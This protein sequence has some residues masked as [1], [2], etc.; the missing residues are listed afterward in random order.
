[1]TD[2]II[3]L[4]VIGKLLELRKSRKNLKN[5]LTELT[6]YDI[7]NNGDNA[8]EKSKAQ[9]DWITINHTKVQID[10]NG[11]LA[12]AVGEKIQNYEPKGASGTSPKAHTQSREE[13]KQSLIA[14]WEE[15]HGESLLFGKGTTK[16]IEN[17]EAKHDLMLEARAGKPGEPIPIAQAQKGANPLYNKEKGYDGNCQ[18]CAV[19]YDLRRR[20]YDVE[21]QPSA[22][23]DNA[24]LATTSCIEKKY[25]KNSDGTPAVWTQY[26]KEMKQAD[27]IA[28]FEADTKND[29]VG[30]R[31][32]IISTH[33]TKAF[34][35][36]YNAEKTANGIKVIDGQNGKYKNN[37]AKFG[38]GT[39][40]FDFLRIDDKFID[41]YLIPY[42]IKKK[43]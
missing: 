36:I 18:R 15:R 12:G 34:G 35:H 29:P 17:V 4:L 24:G 43:G 40:T 21:A 14:E 2:K 1:M 13:L 6:G 31:Y 28:K 25:Y 3:E 32:C 41:P 42:I 23:G 5:I 22:K 10:E 26:A 19:V 16:T 37:V 27:I 30:A 8:L 33:K 39:K 9:N 38:N 20:G 11:N 7:F